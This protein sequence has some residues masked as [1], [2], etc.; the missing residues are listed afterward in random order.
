MTSIDDSTLAIIDLLRRDAVLW[1]LPSKRARARLPI[2]GLTSALVSSRGSLY[3]AAADLEH[4]TAGLCWRV[5]QGEPERIGTMLEV[6]RD[7]FAA[8]W[9]T[10]AMDVSGDSLIYFGGPSE[11]VILADTNWQSRDSF[12]IPRVSRRGIPL[13]INYDVSAGRNIY[14]VSRQLS[15]PFELHHLSGGRY[16]VCHLDA[17]VANNTNVIGRV[18]MTVLSPKGPTHCVDVRVPTRDSTTIPRLSLAADT[19]FVLDHFVVGDSA[20]ADVSKY[21]I[22]TDAC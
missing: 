1:D 14:D 4:G 7:L 20:I 13:E 2:P 19:L 3:A 5:P 18:F 17:S 21:M 15:K 10:V 6:Y 9:G 8:I 22:G 12:P 16:A 11:Y